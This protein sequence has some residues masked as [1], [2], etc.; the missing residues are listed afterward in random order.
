MDSFGTRFAFRTV[1]L[2]TCAVVA[3]QGPER[4]PTREVEELVSV[5]FKPARIQA[6]APAEPVNTLVAAPP[7]AQDT[8]AADIKAADF[9]AVPRRE[10]AVARAARAPAARPQVVKASM[11]HTVVRPLPKAEP[12]LPAVFVPIR[13]LGLR[14]QARLGA[15]RDEKA[16]ARP[17][18]R[19]RKLRR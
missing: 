13:N 7:V 14:L 4:T 16:A 10:P 5:V 1:V 18:P 2:L 19:P 3:W 15:P 9:K 6:D 17:A 8:K 11:R 12:P